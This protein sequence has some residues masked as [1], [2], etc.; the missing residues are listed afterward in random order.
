ML[1]NPVGPKNLAQES[2]E[3]ICARFATTHADERQ[4]DRHKFNG[5]LG[6]DFDELEAVL[7]ISCEKT[8]AN[9]VG[10]GSIRWRALRYVGRCLLMDV[11][12]SANLQSRRRI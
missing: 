12:H 7:K 6:R 8:A 9:C 10:D 11:G 4:I 1:G 5:S 3:W 2:E